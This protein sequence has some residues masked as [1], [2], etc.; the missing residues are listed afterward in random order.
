MEAV[1]P[2]IVSRYEAYFTNLLKAGK[3]TLP[4]Q[5]VFKLHEIKQAIDL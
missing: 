3:I 2:D 4:V 1:G 5:K